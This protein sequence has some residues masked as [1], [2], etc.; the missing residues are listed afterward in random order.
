MTPIEEGE[1]L[2]GYLSRGKGRERPRHVS[3]GFKEFIGFFV[4]QHVARKAPVLFYESENPRTESE[5]YQ[6]ESDPP[7]L[8]QSGPKLKVKR[9]SL[10]VQFKSQFTPTLAHRE[11]PWVVSK[12]REAMYVHPLPHGILY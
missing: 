1:R 6:S 4:Y 8:I 11:Y 12:V 9:T 7:T 5:M 2:L 10:Q 3:S